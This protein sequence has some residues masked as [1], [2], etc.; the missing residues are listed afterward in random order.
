MLFLL[1]RKWI[2]ALLGL[3]ALVLLGDSL[4]LL[5]LRIPAPGF[6]L[7]AGNALLGLGLFVLIVASDG[8][9]HGFLS[10]TFGDRYRD[11]YRDL[12]GIF[13]CQTLAAMLAGAAMAGIGEEYLFRGFS[14]QPVILAVSAIIFGLL[15]HIG[16][17]FWPFTIWS[18]YQ[19][20]LLAGGVYFTD[21]LFVTMVAHF[22]HDLCGF[23]IFRWFNRQEQPTDQAN[24]PRIGSPS[25]KR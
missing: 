13:R 6:G 12:A 24:S 14:T 3:A 2:T 25:A 21:A 20:L 23:L 10:L 1:K 15:H 9:V 7:S 17:R 8:V 4:H 16:R 18:G 22:L 11:R 5:S 19:G